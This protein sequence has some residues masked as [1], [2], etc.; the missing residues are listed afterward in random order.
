MFNNKSSHQSRICFQK[1]SFC[2]TCAMLPSDIST[3][4]KIWIWSHFGINLILNISIALLSIRV[5]V[6]VEICKIYSLKPNL[7]IC[8][9]HSFIWFQPI[10]FNFYL[11]I[12]YNI[13]DPNLWV[14]NYFWYRGG[15]C[16]ESRNW[17][18][19]MQVTWRGRSENRLEYMF[20]KL[21][22]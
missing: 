5:L 19:T 4:G 18:P 22:Y 12:E 8:L 20:R 16:L 14:T 10:W 13:K 7:D 17:T 1:R 11:N 6:L 9:N 3:M 21:Y 15:W 2:A